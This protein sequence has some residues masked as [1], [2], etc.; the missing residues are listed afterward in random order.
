MPAGDAVVSAVDVVAP[1]GV[2]APGADVQDPQA[3]A[4]LT[5]RALAGDPQAFGV[6]VGRHQTRVYR[7]AYRMLG[8]SDDAQDVAQDVWLQVWVSLATFTG[9]A[10]FSTWLSRVAVNSAISHGRRTSRERARVGRLAGQ[11]EIAA[12]PVT[13]SSQE[14][15]E[16]AEQTRVVRTA[17][18]ALQPDLRA[19]LVLR[20]FERLSYGEI[21]E[22]LGLTE[23]T[24]RGRLA[25]ARRTLAAELK[26]WR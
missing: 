16:Q 12:G 21:G 18:A 17:V 24:V 2:V 19:V 8:N 10:A 4:W 6:L 13:P 22:V 1:V 5:A 25:R 14:A 26:G 15:A 7:I 9:S 20:E 11:P 23:P 3:D